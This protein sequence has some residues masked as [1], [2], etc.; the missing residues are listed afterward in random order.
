MFAKYVADGDEEKA[1]DFVRVS[2][3]LAD[4]DIN[5]LSL[6]IAET[7]KRVYN[8]YFATRNIENFIQSIKQSFGEG[9]IFQTISSVMSDNLKNAY[10]WHGTLMVIYRERLAREIRDAIRSKDY[11]NALQDIFYIFAT[12]QNENEQEALAN[13]IGSMFG[14]LENDQEKVDIVHKGLIADAHK[15]KISHQ[16]I[17]NIENERKLRLVSIYK[18]GTFVREVEWN[19]IITT[20][21]SDMRK[22]LPGQYELREPTENDLNTFRNFLGSIFNGYFLLK[23]ANLLYDITLLLVEFCPKQ[24]SYTASTTGI[25]QRLYGTLG[26]TARQT[27]NIVLSE[28][29]KNKI[30]VDLYLYFI[31]KNPK[32]NQIGSFIEVVG[33]LKNTAFLPILKEFLNDKKMVEF[34]REIITSLS[35]LAEPAVVNLLLDSFKDGLKKQ[36]LEIEQKRKLIY[37]LNSIRNILINQG[38]S[39]D[40]R[41]KIIGKILLMVPKN[42]IELAVSAVINLFPIN[43][44]GVDVGYIKESM[45]ILMRGLWQMD[46]LPNFVQ[47]LPGQTNPL[48]AFRV[49]IINVILRMG[50]KGLSY[51]LDEIK[52][53]PAKLSGAYI[54]YCEVIG[55]IGDESSLDVLQQLLT[56]TILAPEKSDYIYS[57]EKIY[58]PTE[59]V[60]KIITKDYIVSNLI[61]TIKK[62]GGV[63]A[64]T[65]LTDLFKQIQSGRLPSPGK[66]SLEVLMNAQSSIARESGSGSSAFSA[67]PETQMWESEETKIT[68]VSLSVEELVKNLKPGILFKKTAKQIDALRMLGN[69][70]DPMVLQKIINCLADDDKLVSAA[71]INALLEYNDTSIHPKIFEKFINSITLNLKNKDTRIRDNIITIIKQIGP[72]REPLASKLRY[73][74]NNEKSELA[75]IIRNMVNAAETTA[76]AAPLLSEITTN[77]TSPLESEDMPSEDVKTEPNKKNGNAKLRPSPGSPAFISEL[78]KKRQYLQ[79]RQE[80]LRSGKQGPPPK[81]DE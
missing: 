25:E 9:P 42:E 31:K 5:H 41:N 2:S 13:Y 28:I 40:L 46:S 3:L 58:D 16:S 54:A 63:K 6:Q 21:I 43:A 79:A 74:A 29:G 49:G 23:N 52:M 67:A 76:P 4:E 12:A 50:K 62:I 20:T 81:L 51:F 77:T 61:A 57:Q 64:N 34:K 22:Y 73:I 71:A 1:I 65:I 19:R 36:P 53:S 32:K 33:A 60:S 18:D 78:E 75:V 80:W 70:K 55:R 69:L 15:Y 30:I 24:L 47:S 10:Q 37:I 39:F 7:L 11:K 59:G 17:H 27:V 66:E 8:S 56:N 35:Y 14:S 72:N 68:T 44:D 48:S 26:Q 45:S 38:I